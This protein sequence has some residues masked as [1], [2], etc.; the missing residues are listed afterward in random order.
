VGQ[1]DLAL[2]LAAGGE[3]DDQAGRAV[4]PGGPDRLAGA[5]GADLE[6]GV[7]EP[8]VAQ[9]GVGEGLVEALDRHGDRLG[10]VHLVEATAALAGVAQA[11]GLLVG[12]GDALCP[13]AADGVLLDQPA[14][15]LG[16]GP[17]DGPPP[18]E[19]GEPL[20]PAPA[21]VGPDHLVGVRP[22][23]PGGVGGR[24]GRL[25]LGGGRR[26][27]VGRDLGSGPGQQLAAG[28]GV[29]LG[30][31]VH[32]GPDAALEGLLPG[33]LVLLRTRAAAEPTLPSPPRR[34]HSTGVPRTRGPLYLHGPVAWAPEGRSGA[35]RRR[36]RA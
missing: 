34:G 23:G 28:G 5:G 30:R 13:P 15:D 32:A 7:G 16:M 35:G 1:G 26:R 33:H 4:V 20:V 14:G 36:S 25:G 8:A 21:G 3:A 12:H 9:G 2:G 27:G 29:A 24:R 11:A 31:L 22:P 17:L 18:V 19:Q 6:A 10:G